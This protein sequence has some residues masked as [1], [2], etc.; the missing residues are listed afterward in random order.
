MPDILKKLD[1]WS[2]RITDRLMRRM[3][4][5]RLHIPVSRPVVSFTFDDVPDTALT[6]GA[7]ILEDHGVR[8]TF[9]I[10]GSL[11][12]QIEPGR[13]LISREG[14]RALAQQGHEIGCHTFSHTKVSHMGNRRLAA[15]LQRNKAYLDSV[16]PQER[17]RNFAYPY[18]AGSFRGRGIFGSRFE[19]CRAGGERI[20]R[21]AVNPAFLW[22]VEIRQPESHACGL[23]HWIDRLIAEEQHLPFEQGA[24]ELLEQ[25]VELLPS[26]WKADALVA[27]TAS[28]ISDIMCTLLLIISFLCRPK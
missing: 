18:N 10:A 23:T 8:G 17:R 12:G 13:T 7:R 20:N 25:I 24:V 2:D 28:R 11:E 21:G 5:P 9:Y 27:R 6:N 14:C 3:P 15:D 22:G 4:G 26:C 16:A 19:T 1:Y